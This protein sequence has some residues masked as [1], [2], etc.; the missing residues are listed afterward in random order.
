MRQNQRIVTA[1][2]NVYGK[3]TNVKIININVSNSVLIRSFAAAIGKFDVDF[4]NGKVVVKT[5]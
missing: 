4:E 1:M 5:K 3:E 2:L